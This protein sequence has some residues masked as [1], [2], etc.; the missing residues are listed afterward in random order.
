MHPI[1]PE[2]RRLVK[3]AAA[4]VPALRKALHALRVRHEPHDPGYGQVWYNP[5][6]HQVWFSLS[7]GDE[8]PTYDAW[9]KA[10]KVKGVTLV[11]GE[12]EVGPP[13]TEA[14]WVP[15]KSASMQ[16]V[17]GPVADVTGW[18]EGPINA[19]WGGSRPLSNTL[20]GAA[21]G[22]GAGY[23]AGWLAEHLLPETFQN[24][25]LRKLFAL[26]GGV[27]GAVPGGLTMVDSLSRGH[28]VLNPWPPPAEPVEKAAAPAD[29]IPSAFPSSFLDWQPTINRSELGEVLLTDPHLDRRLAMATDGL[30]EAASLT[31]G[32]DLVSPFDIARI[33]VG[34]GSGLL[35]GM[36]VGKTLGAIAGL[37]DGAQRRLQQA[38]VLGGLIK[39]VVPLAFGR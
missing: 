16:A 13:R 17:L 19:L 25:R 29:G 8:Q 27:A 10:L 38:G 11:R 22:A 14:A 5:D 21:L 12:A 28:G 9:A 32:S 7:D 6:T 1:A 31:R 18:K 24:R 37:S 39:G 23:G 36:L 3:A 4:V 26:A 15:V 33:A 2:V 30:L 34:M 35:S 20:A